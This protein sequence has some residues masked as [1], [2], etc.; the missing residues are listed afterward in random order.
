M[1]IRNILFILGTL[2]STGY[3]EQDLDPQIYPNDLKEGKYF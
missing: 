2:I 3:Q 1:E